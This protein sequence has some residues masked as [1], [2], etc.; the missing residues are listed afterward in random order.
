VHALSY[1]II[2]ACRSG[3]RIE[4]SARLPRRASSPR[5]VV[6]RRSRQQARE[7]RSGSLDLDA[8]QQQQQ[9]RQQRRRRGHYSKFGGS[10]HGSQRCHV[11]RSAAIISTSRGN[12][13]DDDD[14]DDGN[15]EDGERTAVATRFLEGIVFVIPSSRPTTT[16]REAICNLVSVRRE[17]LLSM[18]MR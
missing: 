2:P 7:A 4:Y 17:L 15:G 1:D 18:T 6:A 16:L 11:P 3:N 5:R 10:R 8:Q 14:D 13:D 9:Q 12:D